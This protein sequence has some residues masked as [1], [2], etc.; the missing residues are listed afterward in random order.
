MNRFAAVFLALI[1]PLSLLAAERR[2]TLGELV[3]TTRR[4]VPKTIPS[5]RLSGEELQRLSARN[6]ADAIRYFAGAHIK[7][8]GG[9]GGVKTV[10]VRGMGTNHTGVVYDGV[11]LGNAQNGQIDLGQ[12]SLDNV[13][14]I[15]LYNGQRSELLQPARDYSSAAAVFF[16]TRRP[17]FSKDKSFNLRARFRTGSFG[18]V[19]PSVLIEKKLG[20][21]NAS[22]SSEYTQANGRYNFRLTRRRPDG[23]I[24]YDT[25]AVRQ[26]GDIRALRNELNIFGNLN[27]GEWSAKLYNYVSDRGIPGAIVNNVWRRG[28]RLGDNNSFAQASLSLAR[29]RWSSSS[30]AKYAYYDTKYQNNDSAQLAVRRHYS[31]QEAYLSTA[32][33]VRVL[34]GLSLSGAYDFIY[35]T[36]TTDMPGFRGAHRYSNLLAF[37]TAYSASGVKIQTN[38]LASLVSDSNGNTHNFRKAFTPGLY[39]AY[40][41]LEYLTLR[42]YY[43]QSWRM[44]TFNDLYYTDAGNAALKPERVRQLNGGF[45]LEHDFKSIVRNI[46]FSADGYYNRVTD[47]IIAYPKGVQFR[48]TMLNLGKV[49]VS[50]CDLAAT[51][52]IKPVSDVDVHL[53]AVYGY[54]NAIDVTDV[55]TSY[56]RHQIPYVPR[57]SASFATNISWRDYTLNYSLLYAGE[58]YAQPENTL[59]NRMPAWITHDVSASK[60]V[61]WEDVTFEFLAEINNLAGHNYAVIR[62]YPMPGR[63]FRLSLTLRW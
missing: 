4:P 38:C 31:Q 40:S 55:A 29:G 42:A 15:D 16:R 6:V 48:W 62:N 26:N 14:S 54:Q 2:D 43:K 25:T 18:L 36:L 63:N 24:A 12:F 27:G 1:L 11:A 22:L 10:D 53:R 45:T 52:N 3:V 61:K 5:Q 21:D 44:P 20:A 35:N 47:K 41:P 9:V 57:H 56:Y 58:R 28:E 13:E 60:I 46:R 59:L 7:D 49:S 30:H 34:T 8:Y 39:S 19:N 51:A 50:G 23:T 37:S 33:S 17:R 32:H